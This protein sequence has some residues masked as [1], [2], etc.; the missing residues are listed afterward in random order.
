[1]FLNNSNKYKLNNNSSNK[2]SSNIDPYENFPVIFGLYF[3]DIEDDGEFLLSISY[4]TNI[5]YNF[6]NKYLDENEIKNSWIGA[7][8]LLLISK[9]SLSKELSLMLKCDNNIQNRFIIS[10]VDYINKKESHK[11]YC[12]EF[13]DYNL[14]P[15]S[16]STQHLIVIDSK[17]IYGKKFN[18]LL[19]YFKGFMIKNEIV[20]DKF[21]PESIKINTYID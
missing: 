10:K 8:D 15:Y 17:I 14:N 9:I 6:R 4:D 2:I 11:L 20:F 19:E 5:L 13:I 21:Y 12:L 18:N 16:F 1:M 3:K 7:I